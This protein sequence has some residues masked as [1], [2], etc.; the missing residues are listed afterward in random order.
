MALRKKRVDVGSESL[1]LVQ[2]LARLYE[3]EGL[4]REIAKRAELELIEIEFQARADLTWNSILEVAV[5]AGKVMKLVALAAGEFERE[6][7]KLFGA[8]EKFY[9]SSLGKR[10]PPLLLKG[11]SWNIDPNQYI[12]SNDLIN[13]NLS[14]ALHSIVDIKTVSDV[15]TARDKIRIAIDTTMSQIAR[16]ITADAN[17]TGLTLPLLEMSLLLP[18]DGR[19]EVLGA[20]DLK[21]DRR[22]IEETLRYNDKPHGI[23][24]H[25]V[26]DNRRICIPDLT[27]SDHQDHDKWQPL[28]DGDSP[29]GM[30]HCSPIESTIVESG[31]K[32]GK[33]L[34]VF[35]M[36]CERSQLFECE[37]IWSMVYYHQ[38]IFEQLVLCW[39]WTDNILSLRRNL[40]A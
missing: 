11:Q 32:A 15:S 30:I 35:C 21:V 6:S 39:L 1:E 28:H 4:A 19:F 24:G 27:D 16:L 33:V 20:R 38:A 3:T 18:K 25:V 12:K 34:G 36:S 7:D 10:S 2:A 26:K 14:A 5:P 22:K 31:S 23:A 29:E 8:L 9:L 37:R 40:A 13:L 17:H